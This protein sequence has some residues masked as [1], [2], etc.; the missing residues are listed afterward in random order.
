MAHR[1]DLSLLDRIR[2]SQYETEYKGVKVL[3]KPI[4]EGGKDGDVDP[5]LFKS[6]KML[7]FIIHFLPKTKKNATLE[8]Q[9]AMPRKMFGEYKGDKIVE[10]G[11]TTEHLTVKSS[12]GYDVPIRI[13]KR[14]KCGKNLPMYIYYHGGGFLG[15]GPHIVEEMCKTLV[16]NLDSIVIN[17]DYR[18]CPEAHYPQPLDDC[19][20]ATVWAFQNREKLGAGNMRIACGGDSAGGNLAAAITLRDREERTGMI[21]L[22][23][24]IYPAVNISGKRTEFYKGTFPSLYHTTRK[25]KK[26]VEAMYRMMDM[27][28]SGGSGNMLEDV[29]LQGNLPSDHIYSSPILDTFNNLPPTLLAFGEHDFLAFEDFAYAEHATKA[30]VKLKTIIYRGLGHGWADQIGVMPQAED[31]MYE[32]ASMMKEV[33]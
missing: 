14:E 15:G 3:V 32:I 25:T 17:V 22:Q 19:W 20:A 30:G 10:G 5:R 7:P 11:V 13:Y 2:S 9:I 24:L 27:M 4:P 31:L 1:F 26:P 8:E 21:G 28:I 6:M 23:T 29:Y 16:Q 18:L 12:D 33:L